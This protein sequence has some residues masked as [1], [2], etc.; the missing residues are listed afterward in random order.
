MKAT[1]RTGSPGRATHYVDTVRPDGNRGTL[2]TGNG[3]VTKKGPG[4]FSLS[5]A[6]GEL[7]V[8]LRLDR[9]GARVASLGV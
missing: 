3:G 4:A 9:Q 6:A 7:E 5:I 1:A 8:A 2:I